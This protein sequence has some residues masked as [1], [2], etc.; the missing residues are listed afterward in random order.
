ML[1]FREGGI[2]SSLLYF[3]KSHPTCNAVLG[4]RYKL[5][6]KFRNVGD[7]VWAAVTREHNAGKQV[8]KPNPQALLIEAFNTKI[9]LLTNTN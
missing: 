5:Y 7:C 3:A 9:E 4:H 8:F 2:Y 1:F 6:E